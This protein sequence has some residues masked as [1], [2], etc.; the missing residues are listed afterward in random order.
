MPRLTLLLLFGCLGAP[1]AR[2][3]LEPAW[4]WKSDQTIE[5]CVALGEPK[6]CAVAVGLRDGSVQ[7]INIIT[8]AP[9]LDDVL[10]G[11]PGMRCAGESGGAAYFF[12]RYRVYAVSVTDTFD[13]A[14]PRDR[15]RW[16]VGN[17]AGAADRESGDPEFI[18][19]LIAAAATPAGVAVLDS[20]GRLAELGRAD[21]SI[22]WKA[23]LGNGSNGTL[24]VEN[25][26][27]CAIVKAAG[28]FDAC[29]ID[30]KAEHPTPRR[31][32]IGGNEPMWHDLSR[33]GLV[34][35]WP[36]RLMR[37]SAESDA[38]RLGLKIRFPVKAALIGLEK[39][40][41]GGAANADRFIALDAAGDVAAH[42]VETQALL[43]KTAPR[44]LGNIR[45]SRLTLAG[46]LAIFTDADGRI[47]ALRGS[48]GRLAA[49]WTAAAAERTLG[50]SA[51]ARFVHALRVAI[52]VQ[53]PRRTTELQLVRTP[54][55][56]QGEWK[57]A[58][59]E[60]QQAAEWLGPAEGVRDC[61]WSPGRV[62]IISDDEVR[63]F[64]LQEE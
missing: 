39:T 49:A 10:R 13:R 1:A 12:D 29:F 8:A 41:G 50:V 31:R 61:V 19:K 40:A 2:A 53:G 56:R 47:A 51:S 11:K 28:G 52:R 48:D 27:L 26:T 17:D 44:E 42:D 4:S 14:E 20:S 5:W 33:A 21:G 23:D 24:L 35:A 62:L 18:E 32:R 30:L 16:S 15:V 45:A 37:A 57:K 34:A 59:A 3:D 9:R 7:V 60:D 43:W 63:M 46:G 38:A 36:G 55:V 22:R 6:D 64:V 58:D 54:I 25:A